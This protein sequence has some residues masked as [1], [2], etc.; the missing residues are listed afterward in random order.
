[1]LR[2]RFTE[3]L[4]IDYPIISA[5]MAMHSGGMLAAAVSAA[6][7]LGTFGGINP[8][9]A[10]WVCDQIAL[11]RATT[12]RP[13][14]VGFITPFIPALAKNFDVAIEER[15]PAV[16]F[17]FSDPLPYLPRAK[18]A[19][20]IAIC[21]VQTLEGAKQA[22]DAGAD[23]L[24]AQGN[25]A[26]GHTGAMSLLPLLAAVLDAY[27]GIPVLAAGGITDAR[28]LAAVLAAGADGAMLG[29]AF[30]ATP[31]AVEVSDAHKQRIVDSDGQDTVYT[32]VF[33]M[34]G[35]APWPKGIAGRVW[36]N[37]FAAE[38]H[39]RED[40]LRR[41]KD[42]IA[43]A[44]LAAEKQQDIDRTAVYYGQGAGAIDAVRPAAGVLRS[45]CDGA[46]RILRDRAGDLLG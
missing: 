4:G 11:V 31:E 41:R 34:L 21:Q 29:T 24:I 12:D 22:V 23:V 36:R 1:M 10:E 46:E 18:D 5:P 8:A 39:G 33:D 13:F 30:L 40:E 25:E 14:G 28:S 45:I 35:I 6:G 20:A 42:E 9:G 15:V 16:V 2:T 38:W 27:P 32:Q 19:G 7:G 44:L 26:G 17:S 37:T 43:P 3:L